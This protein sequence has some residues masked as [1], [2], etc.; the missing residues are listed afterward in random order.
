MKTKKEVTLTKVTSEGIPIWEKKEKDNID[1]L[2]GE[3]KDVLSDY[4]K[5]GF[6][7]VAQ[8]EYEKGKFYGPIKTITISKNQ[9]DE[10]E[11]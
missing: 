10:S 6:K 1:Y 3:L 7:V 11:I 2:E 4:L 5:S 9:E 8:L